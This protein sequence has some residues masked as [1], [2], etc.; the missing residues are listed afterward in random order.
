M[1]GTPGVN[2]IMPGRTFHW[3]SLRLGRAAGQKLK[4]GAAFYQSPKM[5]YSRFENHTT[6]S[7]IG[8]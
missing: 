5:I 6:F 8:H 3:P 4:T 2:A 7:K 1:A